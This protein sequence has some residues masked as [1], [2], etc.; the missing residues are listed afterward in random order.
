[1]WADSV[2]AGWNSLLC[3]SMS[4][5][6]MVGTYDLLLA[7]IIWKTCWDSHSLDWVTFYDKRDFANNYGPKLVLFE[8]YKRKIFVGGPDLISEKPSRKDCSPWGQ[9]CF[10]DGLEE[11][12]CISSVSAR[13]WISQ[14]FKYL[15]MGSSLVKPPHENA[16]WVTPKWLAYET[17]R[18]GPG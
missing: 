13:K 12:S 8:L 11:A 10:P 2:E 4:F 5:M 9:R 17:L 16:P 18:W 14:Q 15:E 1:M 7:I 6:C 3:N